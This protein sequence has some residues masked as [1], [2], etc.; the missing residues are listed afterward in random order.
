MFP[1]IKALHLIGLVM[2]LGSLL[3]GGAV[4]LLASDVQEVALV[5]HQRRLI[6]LMTWAVAIPG[7]WLTGASGLLLSLLRGSSPFVPRWLLLKQVLF[8]AILLNSTFL[9]APL[10]DQLATVT[11][12]SLLTGTLPATYTSLQGREIL[13]GITNVALLLSALGLSVGHAPARS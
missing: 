9:L 4:I 7:M 2:F 13:L 11:A 6:Q 10:V 12:E 8:L 3:A 5:A 1:F